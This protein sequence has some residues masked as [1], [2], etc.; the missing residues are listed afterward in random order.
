MGVIS[1]MQRRHNGFFSVYFN[2]L[3]LNGWRH[4][5][6][7][8]IVKNIRIRPTALTIPTVYMFM[9]YILYSCAS[10]AMAYAA[11][12]LEASSVY[13]C[14]DK[15]V[16]QNEICRGMCSSLHLGIFSIKETRSWNVRNLVGSAPIPEKHN[17]F[18]LR[19]YIRN[20][21]RFTYF[22]TVSTCSLA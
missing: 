16:K 9:C 19:W 18:I 14:M 12:I 1:C 20:Q 11:G 15:V 8:N 3:C 7:D 13:L 5:S 22:V 17:I 10:F 21:I 4:K 2:P 6:C